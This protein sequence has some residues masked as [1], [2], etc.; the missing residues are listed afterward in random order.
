MSNNLCEV[1]HLLRFWPAAFLGS[2]C[3][4]RLIWLILASF[5]GGPDLTGGRMEMQVKQKS[6]FIGLH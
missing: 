3:K 2:E 4:K 1:G 6:G 5:S